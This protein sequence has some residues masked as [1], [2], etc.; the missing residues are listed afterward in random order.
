VNEQEFTEEYIKQQSN[1]ILRE[2]MEKY[3]ELHED[4][5]VLFEEDD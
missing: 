3:Q 1:I 2:L 5:L 4:Y